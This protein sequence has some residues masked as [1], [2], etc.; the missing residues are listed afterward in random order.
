MMRRW[1]KLVLNFVTLCEFAWKHQAN[2]GSVWQRLRAVGRLARLLLRSRVLHR[3]TLA[4]LGTRS[5]MWADSARWSTVKV[6]L[7]NPPDFREMLVWKNF[8]REGDIFIDVGANAGSYSIWAADIGAHVLALEP[9]EDTY[10]LLV[11]NAELNGYDVRAI[12]AAAGSSSGTVRFTSRRDDQNRVDSSGDVEVP[13]ISIDSLVDGMSIAGM[14]I[15]VEGSE[16]DV[17]R[18]CERVLREHRVDLIQLEWN[19][20]S[21][22]AVHSDRRPVQD[23]LQAHGYGLFRPD[24]RGVLAPVTDPGFGDDVFARPVCEGVH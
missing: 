24:N 16:I 9:A 22:R 6:I 4:S 1:D 17:L 14:K 7:G 21:E 23:L 8:L 13:M 2:Q 12:R 3:R 10:Q 11:E 15:D 18:G 19:E 20:T 5:V